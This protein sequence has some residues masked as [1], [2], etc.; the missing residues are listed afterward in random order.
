MFSH[1]A[2]RPESALTP[3]K[4]LVSSK[5]FSH[6]NFPAVGSYTLDNCS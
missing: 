6:D 1:H 4:P 3:R 2:F 5:S